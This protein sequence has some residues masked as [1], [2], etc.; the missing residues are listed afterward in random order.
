MEILSTTGKILALLNHIIRCNY[1]SHCDIF[2]SP[3]RSPPQD[4]KISPHDS[5]LLD[6]IIHVQQCNQQAQPE[7]IIVYNEN[8]NSFLTN[9]FPTDFLN[10]LP[11]YE[12]NQIDNIYLF[13]PL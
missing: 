13:L 6:G 4:A 10:L 5:F 8:L 9:S 7:E 12:R 11:K 2:Y 3:V 1:L